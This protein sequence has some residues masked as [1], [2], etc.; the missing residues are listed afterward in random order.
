MS[1]FG[2]S[3]L[4]SGS[5]YVLGGVYEDSAAPKLLESPQKVWVGHNIFIYYIICVLV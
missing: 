3:V 1:P 4:G 5:R 2:R